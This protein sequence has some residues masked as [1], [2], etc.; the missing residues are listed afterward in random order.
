MP[1][2]DM[3]RLC[4]DA[5][6]LAQELGEGIL[7]LILTRGAGGRGYRPP[8]L[9]SSRLVLASFPAPV[10]RDDDWTKGIRLRY[11]RTPASINPALAG[12]KHLNR[13]DSVLARM[14]WSDPDIV[15]GLM[16]DTS[17]LIVG[18]TM[19]N[20]FLWAQGRLLTPPVVLSGVAGTVRQLMMERAPMFGFRC[21]IADLRLTDVDDADG[22]ILTNAVLGV[23]PARQLDERP[24]DLTNLP[25]AL[26][27]AV[28]Q[29]A[30]TP[31]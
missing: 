28:R 17:G 24:F 26:L 22:L 3:T 18:G 21:Q 19:T 10:D 15:E 6:R 5:N 23:L 7:K 13:L 12:L 4:A 25:W 29:A 8:A 1:L 9:P 14:E 31:G 16:L 11:C 2:P 30:R 20:L 27:S